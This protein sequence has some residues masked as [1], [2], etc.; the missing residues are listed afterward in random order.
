MDIVLV[1]DR[2]KPYI[3]RENDKPEIVPLSGNGHATI[4]VP[5]TYAFSTKKVS[6]NVLGLKKSKLSVSDSICI[7]RPGNYRIEL[8]NDSKI[9]TI[10]PLQ[11]F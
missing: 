3:I 11:C 10:T 4:S 7:A 8:N 2:K 1:F 6:K 9:T 5:G